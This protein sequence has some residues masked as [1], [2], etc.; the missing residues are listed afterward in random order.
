MNVLSQGGDAMVPILSLAE[1]LLARGRRLRSA[2]FF[3]EAQKP[4][5][6]MLSLPEQNNALSAE[7]LGMLAEMSLRRGKYKRAVRQLESALGIFP[8]CPQF[9]YLMGRALERSKARI[10]ATQAEME[11]A[12][13]NYLACL[14]NDP[15]HIEARTALGRLRLRQG[16]V[17]EGVS[18]LR[19]GFQANPDRY[20]SFLALYRGLRLAR[21]FAE[22]KKLLNEVRF[23]FAGDLRFG[24]LLGRLDF[25]RSVRQQRRQANEKARVLPFLRI[26]DPVPQPDQSPSRPTRMFIRL[27][28]PANPSIPFALR[29]STKRKSS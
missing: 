10:A 14:E 7:T 18:I 2:G 5:E 23:R 8:T 15:N 20:A 24:M 11:Q 4:L 28:P 1:H 12:A 21:A 17:E 26:A 29:K 19:H 6:R 16:L 22:A 27:D 3:H 25:N 13:A 9:L